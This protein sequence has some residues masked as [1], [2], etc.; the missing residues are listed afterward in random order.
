MTIDYDKINQSSSSSA[1]RDQG[2]TG[3]RAIWSAAQTLDR[4]VVALADDTKSI[5]LQPQRSVLHCAAGETEAIN[6][7]E[8]GEV[9][10]TRR[11]W[12]NQKKDV[13]YGEKG[14]IRAW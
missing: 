7:R 14:M 9:G 5:F 13:T 6:S 2:H 1:E 8:R 11:D 12:K 4:L 3:N 10:S